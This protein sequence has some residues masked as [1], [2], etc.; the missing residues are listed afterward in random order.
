LEIPRLVRIATVNGVPVLLHWSV[1]ALAAFYSIATLDRLFYAIAAIPSYLF[2]LIIHELGHQ[3]VA[4]HLG[5]RVLAVEI[6]PHHGLCRFDHPATKF[7]HAKIAWGGVLGQLL[8]AV[9]LIIRVVLWGYSAYGPL[10]AVLAICGP[11]SFA[12]AVF[13]LLPIKGLDGAI[14]WSFFPLLWRNRLRRTKKDKSALEIFEE[15]AAKS[16]RS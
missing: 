2:I 7:E 15:L 1:I 14:A 13:N 9:P 4:N 6:Y 5:Y 10:N 11:T 3:F 8:L 12:I 16:K